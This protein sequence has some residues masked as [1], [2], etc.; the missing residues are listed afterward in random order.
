MKQ[1]SEE[2]GLSLAQAAKVHWIRRNGLFW[3][4]VE[5]APGERHWQAVVELEAELQAAY[6]AGL[7]TI[8]I[9]H[10]TPAWAQGTSGVPCGPIAPDDLDD[11]AQFMTEVVTRY[12]DPPYGVRY[13]ELWNEPDVDPSLVKPNSPFGCWGDQEDEYYGGEYYA[14]MLQAVY[15][16]IKAVD[17]Q[18]QVLIGGLLLDK[19][20]AFDELPNPPGRFMEGILRG[21]G[22]DFF[23]I[24]SFHGYAWY[25]GQLGDWERQ[26]SSWSARGGM[27]A[28]KVDFLRELLSAYGYEKPLMLT[29]A[30]LLCAGCSTPP[31]AAFL[32]A[33][34]AYVPRLYI[35]NIALGLPATI[36]YTLDGPGWRHTGLLDKEQQ[37]RPAYKTFSAMTTLL[38]DAD[39]LRPIED[40]GGIVGYAFEHSKG[41]TWVLWSPDNTSVRIPVPAGLQ[42]AYDLTGNPLK[43]HGNELDVGFHPIYLEISPP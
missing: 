39:Y 2:R 8:L 10:H 29:E 14:Q 43:L 13:W 3:A 4:D 42:R 16:A 18:A 36:W 33:Q 28:G 40:W 12:K 41:E 27:V 1:I 7:Q 23:D 35:R 21:G 5:P 19:D 17:P 6:R 34:A 22:G 31:P 9:V 38:A 11:L 25:D 37:P 24:V 15:P 30:G 26:P 20:P 32:E